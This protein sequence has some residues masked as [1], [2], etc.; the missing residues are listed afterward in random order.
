M[1]IT[2]D[3]SL[4]T[5]V[6][7]QIVDSIKKDVA[8]GLVK[9]G[10]RLPTVRNLAAE[11]AINPNTIARAY[12]TLESDG[13]TTTRPGSGTF[14]A[15]LDSQLSRQVK[16]RIISSCLQKAIIDAVH[17][18]IDKQTLYKWFDEQI[19]QFKFSTGDKNGD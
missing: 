8:L 19:E 11:L 18:Q 16:K 7:Q 1:Q 10:D 4:N 6:Y 17:M 3:N 13:I 12:R 14:I 2:L 5:P 9:K 15:N